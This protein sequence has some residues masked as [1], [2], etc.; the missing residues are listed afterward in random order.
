MFKKIIGIITILVIGGLIAFRVATLK[1]EDNN[2]S[3]KKDTQ[4]KSTPVA[5]EKPEYGKIEGTSDFIG[6]IKGKNQ[7]K[8]F[9]EAPGRLVKTRVSEGDTVKKDRVIALLTREITG[10]DYENIKVRAPT[11]GTV[12]RIYPDSGDIVSRETP[13]ALI[14]E[15]DE[16]KISFSIPSKDLPRVN[17]GDIARIQVDTYPDK[18]FTGRVTRLSISLDEITRTAY[19]EVTVQNPNQ[20]LLPGMFANLQIISETRE[21]ALLLPRD[22]VLRDLEKETFHVFVFDEGQAVKKNLQT[23][24]TAVGKIEVLSG[25]KPE[26]Q[27]IVDGQNFLEDGQRVRIPDK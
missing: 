9:P 12:T 19:G 4:A 18:K 1:E 20:L 3:S 13:I 7:A 2:N 25:L 17:K 23:G 16:V 14:S 8:V 11:R 21:K 10:S 27:V 24:I 22:A 26:D 15:L 5:V 6:N